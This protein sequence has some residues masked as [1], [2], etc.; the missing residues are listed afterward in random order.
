MDTV[1]DDFWREHVL[2]LRTD[3]SVQVC[4]SPQLITFPIDFD[5]DDDCK[6]A[7][8]YFCD[9]Q[10]LA[11]EFLRIDLFMLFFHVSEWYKHFENSI[12]PICYQLNRPISI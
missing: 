9:G 7:H 6:F 3:K 1:L 2:F 5:F 8:D 10:A 4:F 11:N 12:F